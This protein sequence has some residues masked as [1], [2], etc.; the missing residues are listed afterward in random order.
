[1]PPSVCTGGQLGGK[2]YADYN[3]DGIKQSGETNG[4]AGVTVTVYDCAGNS[5]TTT[6]DANGDWRITAALTYPVRVEFSSLPTLYGQGTPNGTDGRTTTQFIASADCNVDLGVLDPNDYCQ[7]NPKMFVPCYVYGDP[8]SGSASGTKDALV[9]FDYSAEGFKDPSKMTVIAKAQDVGTIWGMAYNRNI[10]KIFGSATIKRHAGLGPKGL[11]GI[12]VMN[13]TGGVVTSWDANI[14]LGI[15]VGSLATNSARGLTT[16]PG[17]PSTDAQAW[18]AIGKMGIGDMEISEDGNKLWLVNQFDKKLYSIDITAYNTSSTAP[19]AANVASFTIPNPGCTGGDA[20]PFATKVYRGKIYVGVVCDAFTSQNKS[21]LRAYVYSYNPATNAWATVF[22]FPLTY[23]KGFASGNGNG[24]DLTGWYPWSDNFNAKLDAGNSL[25]NPEPIFT[26]IEFDIDGSMILGFGDRTGFQGGVKNYDI[27][28]TGSY[29]GINGGDILRAELVNGVFVLE[30]NAKTAGTV[31]YGSNNNQGPGFG[32]FYNDN[33][34]VSLPIY[35][36]TK[37]DHAEHVIGGL[38][39]RPGSGEVAVVTMDPINSGIYPLPSGFDNTGN[40]LSLPA[41]PEFNS[42][43]VRYMNNTTGG[44]NRAFQVYQSST[45]NADFSQEFFLDGG[46]AKAT[47]LGDLEIGCS[48]PT[49]LQV[50]NYVWVDT[51][52]DGVQDPCE[53]PLSNVTVSLWKGGTQIASTT[54]NASGEYYFSSKSNLGTPADW[55]GT[56]ADTTLLPSMAYEVRI[57]TSTQAAIFSK[58]ALTLAN[59]TTNTGNDQNDNDATTS[60]VYKTIAFTT[61]A[62]GSTNHTYDFGFYPFCDTTLTVS[63]TTTCNGTVVNLF[64]LA[65]GVKGTLTYS[66]NG[67]T[68]TALTNPTNVTP[69]V[70][71]TYFVKDTLTSGCFDIDTLMITVNQPVTAGTGT[72]PTTATCQAGSGLSNINLAGQIT[73]ATSGGTWSQTVGTAVGTALNT[74][75]GVFNPNGIAVGMY[76][77]RY[78]VKGTAPC[79]DAT[80]DITITIQNCCPPTICIPVTVTRN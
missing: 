2:A 22:D 55:T 12:Y 28:G 25:V 61:G 8:Q 54:T 38:A 16:D 44:L 45:W 48:T 15:N 10:S 27:S 67:T 31:G 11:G 9:A 53:T 7:T 32:E 24:K 33:F 74:A 46:F 57:D 52:K 49:Y 3:A 42:A 5:Q 73:G 17:A 70:S 39:L 76:T 66:T 75:T 56:G 77:F 23:P 26:D 59:A 58:L 1:L 79:P 78:T 47:G 63:N 36:T 18:P 37:V 34:V 71:T 20:R 40:N 60:G 13:P 43:G 51:D 19:T 64:T 69:S 6:T 68:W 65:S 30:N 14:D 80:T 4:V 62:A 35:N 41:Y 29:N 21:D 50:G 72:N